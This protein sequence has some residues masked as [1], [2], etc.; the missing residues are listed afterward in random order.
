MELTKQQ[1]KLYEI[2]KEYHQLQVRKYTGE[3]YYKHLYS[4]ASMVSKHVDNTIEIALCHD[5]FEDT[6]CN[7][8]MLYEHLLM[9]RYSKGYATSIVNGVKQLTD[10]FTHDA[11]PDLNRDERK[12]REA[13]RMSYIGETCQSIKY[14]DI[15]DN[16][17]SIVHHDKNFAKI[18]LKEIVHLLSRIKKGN[19]YLFLECAYTV[20]KSL[21]ELN[22]Q[23]GFRAKDTEVEEYL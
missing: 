18:Y 17:R 6:I 7:P 20:Q 14:A 23:S 13:Y 15:I 3:P 11:F 12:R 21:N 8:I 5:L 10:E 22:I 1:A 9:I 4:V 19:I 16:T 2:V